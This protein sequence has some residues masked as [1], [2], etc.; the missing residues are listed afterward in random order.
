M[1]S[2]NRFYSYTDQESAK[3]LISSVD[4]RLTSA[5]NKLTPTVFI[6]DSDTQ[7][8]FNDKIKL[9]FPLYSN[10][11]IQFFGHKYVGSRSLKAYLYINVKYFWLH[12]RSAPRYNLIV[13]CNGIDI[14]NVYKGVADYPT[15]MNQLDETILIDLNPNDVI[16]VILSKDIVN[17]YDEIRILKNSFLNFSLV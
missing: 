5:E 16:D 2:N 11:S 13:Q 8:H 17:V 12:A 4:S 6:V 15:K 7:I 9:D 10:G 1:F 14:Y 3:I